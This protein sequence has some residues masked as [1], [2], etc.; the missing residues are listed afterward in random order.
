MEEKTEFR[1]SSRGIVESNTITLNGSS[2]ASSPILVTSYKK[3]LV[4]GNEASK[5]RVPFTV[6]NVATWL[7][8]SVAPYL[9]T[10]VPKYDVTFTTKSA[11]PGNSDRQIRVT[12]DQEDSGN[13]IEII[14]KQE[15]NKLNNPISFSVYGE[16][17]TSG[18]YKLYD[19][20]WMAAYPVTSKLI[21]NF[22]LGS[23][24]TLEN[25]NVTGSTTMANGSRTSN[26]V[27]VRRTSGNDLPY[28]ADFSVEPSKDDKYNYLPQT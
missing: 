1:I 25:G 6:H 23:G 2:G 7:D 13:T 16:A 28:L 17:G 10:D 14:V 20:Q 21:V 9:N 15:A 19:I 3:K 11:N 12:L 8:V 27:R 4:N 22:V 24:F 5:E 18:S 26:L